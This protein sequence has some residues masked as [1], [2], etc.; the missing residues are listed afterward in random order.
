MFTKIKNIRFFIKTYNENI[1]LR[2]VAAVKR[3]SHF[4]LVND[5]TSKNFIVVNNMSL[6]IS[7]KSLS[8]G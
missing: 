1:L 4:L 8:F 7:N 2:I 6:T 5:F 3:K